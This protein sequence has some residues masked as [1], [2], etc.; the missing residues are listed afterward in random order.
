MKSN[1]IFSSYLQPTSSFFVKRVQITF[2]ACTSFETSISFGHLISAITEFVMT[3]VPCFQSLFP[4]KLVESFFEFNFFPKI[5]SLSDFI[6][7]RFLIFLNSKFEFAVCTIFWYSIIRTETCPIF[8]HKNSPVLTDT[9]SAELGICT[10]VF[11]NATYSTTKLS[12]KCCFN[13]RWYFKITEIIDPYFSPPHPA[14]AR[15]GV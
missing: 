15:G 3:S 4:V 8:I 6:Y 1:F 5:L 11:G 9:S 10:L 14:P 13:E 7:E 12:N 2:K